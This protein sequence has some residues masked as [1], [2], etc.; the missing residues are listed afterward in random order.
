MGTCGYIVLGANIP[1]LSH[2]HPSPPTTHLHGLP[3][4]TNFA[5][6]VMAATMTTMHDDDADEY[7]ELSSTFADEMSIPKTIRKRLLYNPGRKGR[8]VVG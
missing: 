8:F 7:D 5:K 2:P 1:P 6:W 3:S 4:Q